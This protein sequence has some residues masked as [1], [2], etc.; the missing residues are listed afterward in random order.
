MT[1]SSMRA[2]GLI[3]LGMILVVGA[4]STTLCVMAQA[5]GGGRI[6]SIK[7]LWVTDLHDHALV[8]D[9]TLPPMVHAADRQI[10]FGTNGDL[11]VLGVPFKRGDTQ[12]V[13][14]YVLDT[15]S[16]HVIRERQW[17]ARGTPRVFGTSGG[18][19]AVDT[20]AGTVLYGPRLEE[21]QQRTNLY[22]EMASCDG[23]RLAARTLKGKESV[24]VGLDA[25][26]LEPDGWEYPEGSG[27]SISEHGSA[28]VVYV[29]E[30]TPVVSITS[31]GSTESV[32]Y[33][34]GCKQIGV[35]FLSESTLAVVG[36]DR[37]VVI[38]TRGNELMSGLALLGHDVFTPAR[39][40]SR[41]ALNQ[42]VF[43]GDW[44][45]SL[46][47]E[48]VTVFDLPARRA[49]LQLKIDDLRGED[50]ARS[51]VAVSPDGSMLAV[52]SWGIVKV[53]SLPSTSR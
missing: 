22:V 12:S 50:L 3:L 44:R 10:A 17:E 46:R 14:A 48:K 1:A 13:R 5:L 15:G 52:D 11:V 24:W 19:Y 26:T 35:D 41:F 53:Y 4:G 34:P 45:D 47:Y 20:T 40:G 49:I 25:V 37:Y 36:C 9:H 31:A 29:R 18:G 27:L 2:I 42:A 28:S 33:R 6:S 21:E 23:R 32:Y 39:N 43:S 51:G 7:P 16:G 38:N 8:R 30:P